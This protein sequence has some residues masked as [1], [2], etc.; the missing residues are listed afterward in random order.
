[1][2]GP[3]VDGARSGHGRRGGGA[4]SSA[5]D[6]SAPLR[7]PPRCRATPL[8]PVPA[9][10]ASVTVAAAPSVAPILG[11][12]AKSAEHPQG[13]AVCRVHDPVCGGLHRSGRSAPA[14]RPTRGSPMPPPGS[15]GPSHRWPAAVGRRAVRL[16]R[17]RRRPPPQIG[18]SNS[19]TAPP[20]PVSSPAVLPV[21]IPDPNRSTLGAAVLGAAPGMSPDAI[22]SVVR[23]NVATA[24]PRPRA[25]WPGQRPPSGS[26]PPA[27]QLV[28]LQRV[29]R[30]P[31]PGR[32]RTGRGGPPTSATA[33]SPSPR[34]PRSQ[35]S[36]RPSR[37]T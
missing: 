22:A 30:G 1:M 26:S 4:G 3:A 9:E 18:G 19:A 32:R 2:R 28:A 34:R 11:A 21:R 14:P 5:G 17:P 37:P 27:A 31:Q 12:L 23:A 20:G 24:T 29:S 25:L 13:R 33:S 15:P 8:H 36:W 35:A 6:F 16:H 7:H 10:P